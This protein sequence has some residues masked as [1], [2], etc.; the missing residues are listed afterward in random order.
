[1]ERNETVGRIRWA[2]VE[3]V[4]FAGEGAAGAGFCGGAGRRE[5]ER[6]GSP[7]QGEPAARAAVG[8]EEVAA[9]ERAL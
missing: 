7:R 9:G 4:A 8:S 3:A 5:P 6:R 1:M 2:G